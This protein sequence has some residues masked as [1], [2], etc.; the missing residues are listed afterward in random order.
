[1]RRH[2][3]TDESDAVVVVQIGGGESAEHVYEGMKGVVDGDL[4][5]MEELGGRVD[6]NRLDKVRCLSVEV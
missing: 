5:G 4:V 2:G 1:M 6:W 3:I